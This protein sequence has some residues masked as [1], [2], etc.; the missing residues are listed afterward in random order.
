MLHVSPSSAGEQHL[1]HR[2]VCLQQGK[3]L[4]QVGRLGLFSWTKG[5]I[6]NEQFLFSR[7]TEDII[8]PHGIPPDLLDRVIVIRTLL[9]TPQEIKQVI[10]CPCEM[11]DSRV[12]VTYHCLLCR[13]SRSALRLKGSPSVRKLLDTWQRLELRPPSGMNEPLCTAP[14]RRSSADRADR[15]ER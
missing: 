11:D 12:S 6:C 3:V 9:Y 1:P 10:R 5:S 13:S 2:G 15:T 4:D 14:D 7:G 8:A